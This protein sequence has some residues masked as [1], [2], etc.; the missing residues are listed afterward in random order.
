MKYKNYLKIIGGTFKGKK[1]KILRDKT[2]KPT[3]VG[4]RKTLFDWL[5][6]FIKNSICLDCFAGSGILSLESISRKAKHVTLIEK[7]YKIFNNI[8]KNFKWIKKELYSII[9]IDLLIWLKKKNNNKFN[10]IFIDPPYKNKKINLIIRLIEKNNILKKKCIIYIETYKKNKSFYIPKTWILY[11]KKY[12]QN[13]KY[14]LF[15]KKI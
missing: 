13:I 15:I 6:P 10:L 8:K 11:K 4:I 9:N 3:L 1:I 7:K 14:K 12:T 2:T 5:N